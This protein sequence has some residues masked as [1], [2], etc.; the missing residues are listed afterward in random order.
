MP[1]RMVDAGEVATIIACG[2]AVANR[3]SIR[4]IHVLRT[5]FGTASEE[6][7][8]AKSAIT[9]CAEIDA[10]IEAVNVQDSLVLWD[11]GFSA[12]NFEI[13]KAVTA[14]GTDAAAYVKA[15]VERLLTNRKP[16]SKPLFCEQG[17]RLISVGK[18]GLSRQYVA[19]LKLEKGVDLSD[20][21]VLSRILKAGEYTVPLG[22]RTSL[23]LTRVLEFPRN[24]QG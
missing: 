20:K 6:L 4:P 10:A 15:D 5:A 22:Y 2:V 1:S 9:I 24:R 14:L 19:K 13:N 16:E 21:A 7:G 17:H 8:R 12:L 18:K 11:G 23:A 3:P